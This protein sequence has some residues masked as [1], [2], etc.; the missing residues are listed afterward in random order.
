MSW[1]SRL[2]N[3]F[4]GD[5]VSSD[6]EREVEFHL[7]ERV[8]ELVA[9]GMTVHDARAR[10]RKQFGNPT[11]QKEQTRERDLFSWLDELIGDVRYG[12]RSLR[13]APV[14]TLVAIVSLALGIGANTA[15]FSVIDAVMLKSLP[16]VHPEELVSLTR[17][18]GD[19]FPKE[20]VEGRSA[21]SDVF[22]NPLWEAIR[23]RQDVF[24]GLFA[25]STESLNLANGGEA[26]RVNTALVSG[27]YFATLGVRSA[28]GR[29]L[30]KSDD[31]RGCPAVAVVS[32]GFSE[33]E[34]GGESSAL[35]KTISLDTH[36][37][38]IVGVVEPRFFGMDVGERSDVFVPLCTRDILQGAGSLDRRE[39]WSLQ[40][41]GRP[42]PKVTPQQI[43]ARFTTL[44]PG[45]AEST[46][47]AHWPAKEL[48]SYR[49]SLYDVVPA[50]SGFS[51]LRQ[52][53][54]ALYILMAIVVLVLLV[55][56]ANVANLLL[57]R[58]TARQREVAVRLALGAGRG[59]V[60]RQLVTESLMLSLLGAAL[61][62][63]FA[64][65]GS[66]A[67]STVL[68]RG[69]SIV[70]LDLSVDLRMLAFTMGVAVLT[71]L[72]FG[73]VPAW[74]AGRVDPQ[75]AMKAGGRG[76]AEGHSRLTLAKSLVV[77][78]VALSLILVAGAGLLLGSWRRVLSIDPG[79]RREQVLLV[80]TDIR[81][82]VPDAA[83][84]YA[85]FTQILQRVRAVPG[86]RAASAS[87][88]TPVS[89][90]SWNG[91]VKADGF[92]PK[93]MQDGLSWM[94]GITS[95]YFG[96]LGTPLLAGRDFNDG[97]R[98]GTVQ[99]A[100]VTESM[101][102]HFFG[103]VNVVGLS[104]QLRDGPGFGDPIQIV[105]LAGDAKYRSLRDS[106]QSIVYL[107]IA[108]AEP[109]SDRLSLEIRTSANPLA[110][111]PSIKAAIAEIDPRISLDFTTLDR[112]VGESVVAM[113]AVALLSTVF[114]GLALLLAAIGLYGIMTY[115]VA[116][117][118]N[119]IG[120]RIALGAAQ[121]RVVRMVLGEVG[122]IVIVGVVLGV[123]LSFAVTR[124]VTTFLYGVQPNDPATLAGA[125]LVL[126]SVGL[127]SAAIPA[128][129][130]SRLDPVTALREE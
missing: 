33:R 29:L 96:T 83:Q 59:R 37:F 68:S 110:A 120:V 18:D 108:Q 62:A 130:A 13:S 73:I 53:G 89:R 51:N 43:V 122:R 31:Y 40:I 81:R 113:R 127:V 91:V 78:Q 32:S 23:D 69:G 60:A 76:V 80:A 2:L 125:G 117:R 77:A 4:R 105:G 63:L 42:K 88:I 9:G 99:V 103:T 97:D 46:A 107:P 49:R 70:S 35:G 25:Y 56:C 54:R 118:R 66:R 86:V 3:S 98:Q 104:F 12:A 15:I 119:E 128:I 52:Y 48:E 102:K 114:G 55:A 34:L 57:A 123:A 71:G 65:W 27:D 129:R 106:A 84:R 90:S 72:L 1:I 8:D 58:A 21:G 126:A 16:V 93:S 112:Q 28:M 26:R 17:F 45:I 50:A 124:L 67:L 75:V 22:T 85:T 14:F 6:V 11:M 47:P 82:A 10:A 111:I 24:S 74:R 5:D 38:Q 87:D 101:A 41:V 92:T 61:G 109:T 19:Q 20:H 39:S 36:T 79:F 64:V 95:N 116:R 115:S 100:I 94:N 121:G 7:N 30:A 44:A